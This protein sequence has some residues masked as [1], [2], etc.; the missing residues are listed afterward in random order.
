MSSILYFVCVCACL[1]TQSFLVTK[2]DP[3]GCSPPDS[4]VHGIFQQDYKSGL[5]FPTPGEL[6]VPRMEPHFLCLLHCRLIFYCWVTYV[7]GFRNTDLSALMK[8]DEQNRWRKVQFSLATQLCLLLCD[9]MDCRTPGFLVHHQLPELVQTNVHWAG[10]AIQPFHP[11]LSPSPPA[12]NLSKQQGLFWWV[13]SSHQVA[14]ILEFQLHISLSKEYSGLI[15]FR[16]DWL[17]S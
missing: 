14:N 2:S 17:I 7:E 15:S 10:D 9:P 3:M 1:F 12:F 4:S 13:S 16:I 11:L 8:G 5:P 6:P